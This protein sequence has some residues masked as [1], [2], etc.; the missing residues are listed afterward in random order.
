M[1]SLNKMLTQ[2]SDKSLTICR[3]Y[4]E[5][6]SPTERKLYITEIKDEDEGEYH[7]IADIDGTQKKESFMFLIFSKL[8]TL[9]IAE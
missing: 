4:V 9:H 3:V 2:S 7:C 1:W 8:F 5:D 6:D